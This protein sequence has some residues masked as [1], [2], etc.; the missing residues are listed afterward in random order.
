MEGGRRSNVMATAVNSTPPSLAGQSTMTS[1]PTLEAFVCSHRTHNR[2]AP[3]RHVAAHQRGTIQIPHMQC[4]EDIACGLEASAPTHHCHTLRDA[5]G[6][7]AASVHAADH[8]GPARA[9]SIVCGNDDHI[10]TSRSQ[11]REGDV[12]G[13]PRQYE[14][15]GY[16]AG[17]EGGHDGRDSSLG[18]TITSQSTCGS[19]SS[20]DSAITLQTTTYRSMPPLGPQNRITAMNRLP[21]VPRWNPGIQPATIT[22]RPIIG[23]DRHVSIFSSPRHPN[24]RHA[25][26][27]PRRPPALPRQWASQ[28]AALPRSRRS[29]VPATRHPRWEGSTAQWPSYCPARW[30]ICSGEGMASASQM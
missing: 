12:R 13:V 30:E 23:H 5:G 3:W 24:S 9:H 2:V 17:G 29:P 28:P 26:G 4:N 16:G 25:Q 10:S 18:I 19:M 21:L 15:I 20:L 27:S 7:G 22:T 1:P 8:G 14:A 6:L 11:T